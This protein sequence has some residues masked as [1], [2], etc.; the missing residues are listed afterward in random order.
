MPIFVGKQIH[1]AEKPQPVVRNSTSFKE[2]RQSV[3]MNQKV[4]ESIEEPD[5]PFDSPMV[6]QIMK[7]KKSDFLLDMFTSDE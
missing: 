3:E 7:N 4:A 2:L 5:I 6:E 1:I